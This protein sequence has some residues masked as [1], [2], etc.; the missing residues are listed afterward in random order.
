MQAQSYTNTTIIPQ[1]FSVFLFG[2]RVKGEEKPPVEIESGVT[3]N[4]ALD[5]ARHFPLMRHER[6]TVYRGIY[7][8]DG[9]AHEVYTRKGA[10]L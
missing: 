4:A 10:V 6:L 3:F 1:S 9:G 7:G 5:K 8:K 2:H